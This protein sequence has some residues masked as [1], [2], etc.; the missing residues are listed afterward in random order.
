MTGSNLGAVKGLILLDLFPHTGDML[1]A[2]CQRQRLHSDFLTLGYV[3]FFENQSELTWAETMIKDLM[4][5]K[6]ESGEMKMPNGDTLEKEMNEDL[7]EALPRKPDLNVLVFSGT[8][9]HELSMPTALPKEWQGHATFGAEFAEFLSEF[10]KKYKIVEA[11][12]MECGVAGPGGKKRAGGADGG[13]QQ[14]LAGKVASKKARSS[15]EIP[16]QDLADVKEAL[17]FEAKMVGKAAASL[18]IRALHAVYLVAGEEEYTSATDGFLCGFGKGSFKLVKAAD[19]ASAA[20]VQF[21]LGGSE[22]LVVFNG[23]VC[24]LGKIVSDMRVTKPDAPVCYHN[25]T[26]DAE[27]PKKFTLQQ[28]H[29]INFVPQPEA[30]GQPVNIN[31]IAVKEP[32]DTWK[33]SD[34]MR[35]L[36]AVRWVAKGL[37][38]VKPVIHLKGHVAL[39]PGKAC[40]LASA[41]QSWKNL[42]QP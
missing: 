13:L 30:E 14:N 20:G 31:N 6:I 12:A 11:P 23:Q 28:T 32:M 29:H 19:A 26:L 17:L 25:L 24:A 3:G 18:Q 10:E 36:W 2:F 42:V 8:D 35:L 39:K 16:S 33:T 27:D 34:H 9:A 7:L 15:V 37:M 1:E 5:S 4:I 38:P 21:C 41:K 40:S 22:D